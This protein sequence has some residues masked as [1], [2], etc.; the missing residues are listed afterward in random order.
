[1]AFEGFPSTQ[2]F[3]LNPEL[4]TK[5]ARPLTRSCVWQDTIE[6][7][8]VSGFYIKTEGLVSSEPECTVSKKIKSKSDDTVRVLE[9]GLL[10]RRATIERLH[11]SG[12]YIKTK[13]LVSSEPECTVRKKT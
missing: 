7:L 8:L 4:F 11:V 1:M 9:Q 10:M 12:F 5:E 13:G 6:R 3:L 2:L